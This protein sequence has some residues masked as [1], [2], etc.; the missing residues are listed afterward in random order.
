LPEVGFFSCCPGDHTFHSTCSL[1]DRIFKIE[2][3][4]YK[5]EGCKGGCK[6]FDSAEGILACHDNGCQHKVAVLIPLSEKVKDYC[7]CNFVMI[8]RDAGTD[9]AYCS[10]CKK[11]VNEGPEPETVLEQEEQRKTYT[12]SDMRAAYNAGINNGQCTKSDYEITYE[13][14]RR[15]KAFEQWLIDYN[16][17]F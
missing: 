2:G 11:E 5:V 15:N 1:K 4:G 12:E 10:Q 7:K 9:V 6:N 13:M 8:M 16:K 14:I 3:Y 17:P